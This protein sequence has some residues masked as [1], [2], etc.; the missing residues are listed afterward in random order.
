VAV[1]HCQQQL[2]RQ[3]HPPLLHQRH[4]TCQLVGGARQ[5]LLM[6]FMQCQI[7]WLQLLLLA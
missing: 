5:S 3:R 1:A 6:Q 4:P 7:C 2:L